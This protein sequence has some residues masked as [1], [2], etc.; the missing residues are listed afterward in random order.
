MTYRDNN[1]PVTIW[2]FVLNSLT[3]QFNCILILPALFLVL[4]IDLLLAD[5]QKGY[6]SFT[7]TR[8]KN[9]FSWF[10]A[11]LCALYTAAIV[12]PLLYTSIYLFSAIIC[13]MEISSSFSNQSVFYMGT[14]P[15]YVLIKVLVLHILTL[16]AI[17]SVILCLSILFRNSVTPSIIGAILIVL[18]YGSFMTPLLRTTFKWMPTSHMMLLFRVPNK[19]LV[20]PDFA[21]FTYS[22]SIAYNLTLL[23]LSCLSCFLLIR[24]INLSKK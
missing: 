17:S 4:T 13:G 16:L 14:P 15:I 12:F 1:S 6:I 5:I 9:R 24:R 7:I 22:W 21:Q 19:V 2:D 20:R 18:S 8:V 10:W 3:Q 23:G 11:K